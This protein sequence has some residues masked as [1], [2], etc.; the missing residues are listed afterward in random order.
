MRNNKNRHS[1]R[2]SCS[3]CNAFIYRNYPSII[4]D[5]PMLNFLHNFHC[6]MLDD[7]SGFLLKKAADMSEEERDNKLFELS[8]LHN[9]WLKSHDKQQQ[10]QMDLFLVRYFSFTLIGG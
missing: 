1:D 8:E 10:E 9:N 2:V 6:Q 3:A 4:L 7:V 5:K